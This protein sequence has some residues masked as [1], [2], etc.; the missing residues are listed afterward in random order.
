MVDFIAKQVFVTGRVQK[1]GFRNWTVKQAR[2]LDLYGFVR[3]RIDGT[4]ETVLCGNTKTIDEMIEI[5]KKGSPYSRV[6]SIK[7]FDFPIQDDVPAEFL[8]LP[9]L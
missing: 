9:T 4:V 7:V 5:L 8:L 3:N 2:S 6:D 1:V